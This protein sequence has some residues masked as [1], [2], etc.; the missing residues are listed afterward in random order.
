VSVEGGGTS[1][2]PA[3]A[4][5]KRRTTPAKPRGVA[6]ATGLHEQIFD[7]LPYGLVLVDEEG[8]VASA[9]QAAVQMSWDVER[10]GPPTAC[11]ELFECRSAG[12]P[13]EHGCLAQRAAQTGE[14]LPEIRIDTPE[15]SP[16]SAVWVTAA[17]LGVGSG[18]LLHLRAGD[19]GD[20]RRRSEPHWLAGPELSITAFG[21]IRVDSREG[22]LGGQWLQQ[23]PGQILKFLVCER[24]RVVHGEQVAEALWPRSGRQ[25]LNNVRHFMHTLRSKLEPGRTRG[26]GSTFIVTVRGGY[27]INR[28]H[29]RVDADEF[30]RAARDGLEAAQRGEP[31]VATEQLERAL[32][33]YRGDLLEDEPYAEWILAERDR[34]RSMATDGLRALVSITLARQDLTAAAGHLERLTE[35]EPFDTD[36]QRQL[37]AMW[38]AQG[39]RGE[40][41]RRY[42]T[43]RARLLREFGDTPGFTLADIR[44]GEALTAGAE[45]PPRK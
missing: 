17:P 37:L 41:T 2:K 23:R 16:V 44:P 9:N 13:C 45:R 30:E 12:G 38:L 7:R 21:R 24:N 28:R 31:A 6:S 19:A 27:A 40:A 35:F 43:F 3:A 26:A 14:P 4:G 33:L 5:R 11:H 1:S 15:G 25:G 18:V 39:R 29:V 36:I 8:A 10:G 42:A 34:L 20:R 32:E 22:P